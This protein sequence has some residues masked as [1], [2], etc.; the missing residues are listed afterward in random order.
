MNDT[1]AI[2]ALG[3]KRAEL[4]GELERHESAA[5]QLR[6]DLDA[7]DQTIRLFDPDSDPTKITS[8]GLRP[9]HAAYGGEVA[10]VVLGTLRQSKTPLTTTQLTMHVMADR[11]LDTSDRALVLLVSKRV[12]AGLRHYRK[13]GLVRSSVTGAGSRKHAKWEIAT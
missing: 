10:R 4:S 6:I 9:P 13:K 1:F 5:R 12:G 7:L 8:K 2:S 3:R 11:R